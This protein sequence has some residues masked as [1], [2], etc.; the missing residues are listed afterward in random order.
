MHWTGELGERQMDSCRLETSPS[1][2]RADSRQCVPR[3]WRF[4]EAPNRRLGLD[5]LS[6]VSRLLGIFGQGIQ[7]CPIC[8]PCRLLVRDSVHTPPWPPGVPGSPPLPAHG[9]PQT[10][11]PG[12]PVS[13]GLFKVPLWVTPRH[14]DTL[15]CPKWKPHL[16]F[17]PRGCPHLLL[18]P[19][20][21]PG[22]I[23]M[24]GSCR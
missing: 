15:P 1:G 10:H 16:L 24:P 6:P 17:S 8:P 13:S 21:P 19:R 9:S 22:L 11:S 23:Q 2:Q 20:V 14:H 3:A 12:L 18:F 4:G 7:P 5:R